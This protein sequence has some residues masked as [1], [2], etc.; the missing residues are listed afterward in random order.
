MEYYFKNSLTTDLLK[1]LQWIVF[2]EKY[3]DKILIKFSK[4][5]I[6]TFCQFSI[7]C[8]TFSDVFKG[9]ETL[10]NKAYARLVS[11][12]LDSLLFSTLMIHVF[13]TECLTK[14]HIICVY[15]L[16]LCNTYIFLIIIG[17]E[18]KIF[19]KS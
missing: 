11:F 10:A 4:T 14:Y 1:F 9:R 19:F 8:Q 16:I 2:F 17:F 15:E 18:V 6:Y 7:L 12:R 3:S 5:Q 13:M